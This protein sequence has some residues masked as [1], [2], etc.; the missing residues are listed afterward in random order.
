MSLISK[1][2]KIKQIKEKIRSSIVDKGVAVFVSEPF[3]SYPQKISAINDDHSIKDIIQGT[4]TEKTIPIGVNRIRDYC[5]EYRQNLT[6]IIIPDGVTTIGAYAFYRCS[7][8]QSV[9]IP[10]TVQKISREAFYY[11][12]KL[13]N[14]ELPEGLT[15]IDV[16]LLS[17]TKIKN[18][19][20]PST[21]QTINGTAFYYCSELEVLDM[22]L[23][24]A[25]PTLSRTD[26]FTGTP[27]SCVF[28]VKS[29]LLESFKTAENWSY[30]ADRFVG[31]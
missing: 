29:S 26:T 10:N 9:N 7:Q 20:M 17:Y 8:L 22:T 27:S 15:I 3:S 21:I 6:S 2:N 25:V 31:V 4:V 23:L 5:F 16:G 11:C 12:S 13:E 30:Y 1:L 14:I 24:N 19:V 28:K 18:F